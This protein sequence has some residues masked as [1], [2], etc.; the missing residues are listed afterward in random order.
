MHNLN[1]N[2]FRGVARHYVVIIIRGIIK[3]YKPSCK[4]AMEFYHDKN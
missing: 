1:S 2:N 4:F 3:K